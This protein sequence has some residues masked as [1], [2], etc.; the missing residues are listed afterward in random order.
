MAKGASFC[1]SLFSLFFLL[2]TPCSTGTELG[3]SIDARE[4]ISASSVSRTLSF[5]EVNKVSRSRIRV[6]VSDFRVLRKLLNSDVSVDLYLNENSVR[7]FIASKSYA[8]MPHVN[9][10]S[11]TL[12]GDGSD[13]SKLLSLLKLISGFRASDEIKVSVAFSL[14]FLENLNRNRRNEL[15][16]VLGFIRK[17]KSFVIVEGGFD[18]YGVKLGKFDSLMNSK[19][20]SDD[21]DV[22]IVMMVKYPFDPTRNVVELGD[23]L[24]KSLENSPVSSRLVGLYVEIES[25]A[26]KE[27]KREHE[28]KFPSFRRELLKSLE[29]VSHDSVTIPPDD[30]PTPNIVTVPATNPVTITPNVPASTPLPIP[31]TTP[32]MVP[33]AN[34]FVNPPS[35]ITNPVTTPVPGMQPITN[36]VTTYPAPQPGNIPVTTPVAPPATTNPPA[37]AGQSWCVAKPGVTQAVIQSGLDYACGMGGADCSQIQSGQ[38]CYNPNTLLNHASF[39][40]NSYYQKNPVATSCDFGGA[41]SLVSSNP[42]TGSCIF[43]LSSSSSSSSSTTSP[44]PP[45]ASLPPPTTSTTNPVTT[46]STTNPVTTP[47]TTNPTNPTTTPITTNPTTTPATPFT[48]DPG[49]VTPPSVLNSSSPGTEFGFAT[50]P[51]LSSSSTSKTV[52]LQPLFSCIIIVAFFF[53]RTMILDM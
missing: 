6:L 21:F 40:F 29:T 7:E 20:F 22:N 47:S 35:P 4:S 41:A 27:Q 53:A 48:G 26:E 37:L 28:Q 36:P 19:L 30:S 50:P 15:F 39:A 52:G 2:L 43:P 8:I 49:N 16:S 25:V 23:L 46:P 5:L 24:L 9:I 13:L 14:E 32:V 44:S 10:K 17:T 12:K 45:S 18:D 3:F 33:P 38:S 42:S 11:I 1:V 51:G 31:S 34:P